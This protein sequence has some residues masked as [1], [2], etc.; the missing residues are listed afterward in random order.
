MDQNSYGDSSNA[1]KR[2]EYV[3]CRCGTEAEDGFSLVQYYKGL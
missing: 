3:E 2:T 1:V